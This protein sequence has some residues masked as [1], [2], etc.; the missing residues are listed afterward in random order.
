MH[1]VKP[2]YEIIEKLDMNIVSYLKQNIR[3]NI[4][5]TSWIWEYETDSLSTFTIALDKNQIIGTQ[6]S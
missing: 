1:E 4:T 6:G 3:P 2:K 5:E